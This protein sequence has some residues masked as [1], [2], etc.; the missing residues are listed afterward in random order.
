V[1]AILDL[2]KIPFSEELR[3]W[4][5]ARGEWAGETALVGGEDYELLC[6]VEPSQFADLRA[7]LWLQAGTSLREIGR[8]TSQADEFRLLRGGE[9]FAI[10]KQSFEHFPLLKT[11]EEQK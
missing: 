6:T 10:T 1:G 3:T 8:I 2:E 9:P 5:E 7:D 4:A 11:V